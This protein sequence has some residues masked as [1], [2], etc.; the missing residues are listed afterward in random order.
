MKNS[1]FL[2]VYGSMQLR[3]KHQC[4]RGLSYNLADSLLQDLDGQHALRGGKVRQGKQRTEMRVT[5]VARFA[6][7][8]PAESVLPS[9]S[10]ETA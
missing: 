10:Q 5:F 9:K 4:R 8:G 3:T 2:Q 1:A 7:C 6:E